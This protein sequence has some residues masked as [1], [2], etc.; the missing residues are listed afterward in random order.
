VALPGLGDPWL[1][2][3]GLGRIVTLSYRS[4]ASYQIH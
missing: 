4:S 3:I 1:A 2:R